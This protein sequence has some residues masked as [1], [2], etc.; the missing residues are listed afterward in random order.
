MEEGRRRW[1][2]EHHQLL[3]HWFCARKG[4]YPAWDKALKMIADE[5]VELSLTLA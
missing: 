4:L 2:A 3:V 1:V 5:L